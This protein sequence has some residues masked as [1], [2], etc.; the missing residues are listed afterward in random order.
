ME[1]IER[2]S[3]L[4]QYIFFLLTGL[5]FLLVATLLPRVTLPFLVSYILFLILK[6]LFQL[7]V[8]WKMSR[9]MATVA[10]L[11]ILFFS[12]TYPIVEIVPIITDESKKIEVYIPRV[13]PFLREKNKKLQ[14]WAK[15]KAGINLTADYSEDVIGYFQK[16][17]QNFLLS[18][19]R[20]VTS[21]LEWTLLIPLFLFFLLM[22]GSS[23]RYRLLK[24]VPNPIFERTYYLTHQFSKQFGDYIFAK[25]IEA[26]I[27]GIIITVGLI[28]IGYPFA[29]ILGIIAGITNIIPYLGPFLGAIPA[30][31][32]GL[33]HGEPN[34]TI[35]AVG[36]LYLIAN[37]FDLAL[38]FPILVS[39]IVDLHPIIVVFSVILG[40]QAWGVVGMVISIPL[41]AVGKLLIQ[42]IY[43]EIYS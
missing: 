19:P 30:I 23:I 11:G 29:F 22:D 28:I 3:K 14:A 42:E 31:I 33:I 26:S 24:L 6:P 20:I 15:E 17:T 37:I 36:L 38:V 13:E 43:H 27:I 8:R 34:T 21:T 1:R 2:K 16:G 35:G 5:T 10:T 7:F 18:I 12:V 40:S 39:K 25:F 4:T 41:A 9:F 32:I